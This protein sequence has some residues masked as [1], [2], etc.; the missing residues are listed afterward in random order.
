MAAASSSPSLS[1]SGTDEILR[2]CVDVV[3]GLYGRLQPEAMAQAAQSNCL[4]LA[5][6]AVGAM[7]TYP[8]GWYAVALFSYRV[9]AAEDG[10]QALVRAQ[11]VGAHEQWLAEG[12]VRLAEEHFEDLGSMALAGHRA[13]LELLARSRRGV[14]SIAYRYVS[15][16][17]FR[18]RIT[19][20]VETLPNEDQVR[21]VSNV[22]RAA[23]RYGIKEEEP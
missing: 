21:F 6:S 23:E 4:A 13:D 1:L 17:G 11:Q 18:E 15:D 7:P 8:F 20:I 19:A 16:P 2:R 5:R 3:G 22:S 10:E 12:R 9:G 14:A